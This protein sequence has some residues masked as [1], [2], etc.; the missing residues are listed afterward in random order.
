MLKNSLAVARTVLLVILALT[1]TQ[2]LLFR[3]ATPSTSAFMTQSLASAR[4]HGDR[5]WELDYQWVDW[6]RAPQSVRLAVVAA[7]DHKFPTHHGFDFEAMSEA[8]ED[9]QNGERLRGG[10]TISQ[11]VAR[12]LFLMRGGGFVRK[13]L[14]AYYTVLIEALWPKQ[15][16]LEIYLNVAEFGDGVY[17]IGAASRLYFGKPPER[18]TSHESALLAAVLPS[19]KRLHAERPSAYVLGRARTIRGLMTQLGPSYLISLEPGAA[20]RHG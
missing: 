18:M 14:E 8:W 16:I 10:S 7:E 4:L 2:V 5:D 1:V 6:D 17:G 20:R 15:R 9:Y 19:P 11:Q 12:N 3:W 13:G